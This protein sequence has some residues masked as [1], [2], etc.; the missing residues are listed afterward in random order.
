MFLDTC[1]SILE[2][3]EKATKIYDWFT[4]IS[5]GDQ[6]NSQLRNLSKSNAKVE[7]LNDHILYAPDLHQAINK[8]RS[9]DLNN[10]KKIVDLINPVAEA[11]GTAV[12][13][14]AVVS[15]PEKLRAAF[16]KNPWELLLYV[17][18]ANRTKQLD[19]PDLVP[20]SFNDGG[21]QYIGWQTRGAL[22][23]LFNCDFE[24][25]GTL[26]VPK[27]GEPLQ[28]KKKENTSS[29]KDPTT[30]EA[31]ENMVGELLH[32][33]RLHAKDGFYVDPEIPDNK[34]SGAQS[35]F[36]IDYEE[37]MLA[38][39]DCTVFGSATNFLAFGV[40]GIYYHNDWSSEQAGFH[41]IPYSEFRN[42][43][44]SDPWFHELSFDKGDVLDCSG[45]TLSRKEI[46]AILN[47]VKK[48]VSKY[49]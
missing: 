6:M 48:I 26:Y 9:T 15:T 14:S 1:L 24:F 19:N 4:G 3:T 45:S 21:V 43:N 35:K 32:W 30:D 10:K 28:T 29:E 41:F 47:G 39:V 8:D 46:L 42:R 44:F 11:M 37:I 31:T 33:F 25:N 20:I 13:A 23:S 38:L 27:K 2:I 34:F 12:L 40:A 36:E 7:R 18:P 16:K 5:A 22:P 17:K 49:Y